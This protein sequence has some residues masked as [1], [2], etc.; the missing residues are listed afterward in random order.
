MRLREPATLPRTLDRE[1]EDALWKV[2]GFG[3]A[4]KSI[5]GVALTLRTP[6]GREKVVS[7]DGQSVALVGETGELGLYLSGRKEPA[8]V[9][10][11]TITLDKV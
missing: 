10:L 8:V 5:P 6:G 7:K 4:K 11:E 9:T 1:T 2:L 3:F